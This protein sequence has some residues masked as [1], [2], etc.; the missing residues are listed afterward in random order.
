MVELTLDGGDAGAKFAAASG[1]RFGAGSVGGKEQGRNKDEKG[2][3]Q[4]FEVL[5]LGRVYK[6][7]TPEMDILR[8]YVI[9]GEG[10]DG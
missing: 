4:G 9:A 5:I 1:R 10:A 7:N 6:E 3:F 8:D 2:G